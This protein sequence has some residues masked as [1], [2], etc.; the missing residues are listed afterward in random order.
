[1]QINFEVVDDDY[2]D[3]S[4]SEY[5]TTSSS[6]PKQP[7]N[8]TPTDWYGLASRTSPPSSTSPPEWYGLT[9]R[10]SSPTTTT[11]QDYLS[12]IS[13]HIDSISSALRP[14]S[15]KI[16]DNPELNFKEYIAHATLVKFM[17]SQPGWVV[18][19]HAYGIETAWVAVY[20]SGKKGPVISYNAEYGTSHNH[21]T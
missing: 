14:I 13:S 11:K 17:Q 16:H 7:I 5:D 12:F 9:C 21:S 8:N 19:P 4:T 6:K 3:I 10:T 1:M 18:T 20:D 2:V 15:L